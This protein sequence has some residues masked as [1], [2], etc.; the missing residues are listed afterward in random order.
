MKVK[1][2][3]NKIHRANSNGLLCDK[4]SL[5]KLRDGEVVEIPEDAASELLNMGFVDKAKN[6]KQSKEA[7]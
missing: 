5:I 1:A 6:K 3:L 7:K 2:R 4:A